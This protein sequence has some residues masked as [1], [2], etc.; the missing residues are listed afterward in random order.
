L[1]SCDEHT[2]PWPSRTGTF[3]VVDGA[4][5]PVCTVVTLSWTITPGATL[6]LGEH[7]VTCTATDEA[8][9]TGEASFTGTVKDTTA[10]TLTVPGN[11][12]LEATSPAGRA[13]TCDV[14]DLVDASCEMDCLANSGDVFPI[15]TT[16]VSGAATDAS[17]NTTT[18]TFTI[19][20]SDRTDPSINWVGGPQRNATYIFGN[21]PA[22]PAC[23]APACTATDIAA[24]VIQCRVTGYSNQ[25]GRQI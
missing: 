25:P 23:T 4:I 2:E 24:P 5:T 22:A 12:T 7:T 18:R 16:T 6:A 14:T 1:V 17:D 13:V 9:N 21:V 20:I 11:Q 8:G 10:P 19:T 15:G 3:A